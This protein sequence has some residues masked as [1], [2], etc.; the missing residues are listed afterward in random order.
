MAELGLINDRYG[1]WRGMLRLMLAHAEL[2]GGGGGVTRIDPATV[3]RLV[4]VCHGNICRS[5]FVAVLARQAGLEVAS[6]GFSTATDKPAHPPLAAIA[7]GMG[8]DLADHRSTRMQDFTPRPGDLLLAMETRHLR[9][10]AVT[11]PFSML[12]RTLL[13][14]YTQPR[15]PHL[16]D[17]YELGE[18]YTRY[19][20]TRIE[21]AIPVL[22]ATFRNARSASPQST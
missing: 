3:R 19:C 6:F 9:K 2:L 13:G 22:A 12:P 14:L 8:H 7:A 5:A 1:T 17:P 15:T 4:F 16:H 20:L 11:P 10:L 21:T 18:G